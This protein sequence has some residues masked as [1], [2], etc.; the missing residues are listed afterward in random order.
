MLVDIAAQGATLSCPVT[1]RHR[2]I[3]AVAEVDA[4]DEAQQ[5]PIGSFGWRILD[6]VPVP[7]R[8]S[9]RACG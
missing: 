1:V 2:R 3:E 6:G 9:M 7:C 5:L 4:E 8:N